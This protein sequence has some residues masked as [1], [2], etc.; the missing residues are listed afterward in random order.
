MANPAAAAS[1]APT[2][3]WS[4]CCAGY[5][6]IPQAD[7]AQLSRETFKV[8]TSDGGGRHSLPHERSLLVARARWRRFSKVGALPP[9]LRCAA[10]RIYATACE[11]LELRGGKARCEAF[12]RPCAAFGAVHDLEGHATDAC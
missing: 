12:A 1:P 10:Q 4:P 11:D 2:D 8:R 6:R 7:R 5:A 9:A 3:W